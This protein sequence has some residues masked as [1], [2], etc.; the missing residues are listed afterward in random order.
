MHGSPI[1]TVEATAALGMYDLW[2]VVKQERRTHDSHIRRAF[3]AS[4]QLDQ[5]FALDHGVR[6]QEPKVG[7]FIDAGRSNADIATAGEPQVSTGM[8]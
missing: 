5:R 4:D 3:S 7:K 8:N 2:S 6:V 1:G